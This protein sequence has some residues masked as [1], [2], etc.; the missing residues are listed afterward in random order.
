M[1]SGS[2]GML[3]SL[4]TYG[5][6]V[7]LVDPKYQASR[8]YSADL[9]WGGW[10]LHNRFNLNVSGN[11]SLNLDQQGEIDRNFSANQ[12]FALADEAGRPVFVEPTSI[13]PTTGS[14]AAGD[15][16]FKTNGC[17]NWKKTS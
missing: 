5:Q 15:G 8:R 9:N 10:V 7:T 16:Y 12:R 2:G 1:K 11:Y 6:G 3:G 14:I 4:Y 17:K 13:V